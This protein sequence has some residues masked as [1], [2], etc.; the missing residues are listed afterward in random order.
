[1]TI[2]QQ[3]DQLIRV[4]LLVVPESSMMSLASALDPMRAANR[5]SGR[6][7]FE[8]KIVTLSG[9]PASLTCGV[10]VTASQCLE[11]CDGGDL[12]MVIAGFNQ[13]EHVDRGHLKTIKQQSRKYFCVGGVEAG[14]WI[15]ARCGLLDGKNA[16]THWEDLEDFSV[17]FPKINLKPDRFV[18][19]GNVFTTGG[20]SPTFDFMLFLIRKRY[21]YPLALEVSSTFIYDGVHSATDTQPLVSLGMLENNEPRGPRSE[22]R[23]G[24]RATGRCCDRYRLAVR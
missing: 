22:R 3:S 20:A 15:L 12:L 8:W 17:Q 19:D 2:F 11:E 7:L 4:T 23:C 10:P 21:G 24:S 1:M 14:S 9:D 6:S 5:I 13:L 16:T 18:I